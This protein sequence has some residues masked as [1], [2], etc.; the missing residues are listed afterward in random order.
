MKSTRLFLWRIVVVAMFAV[1]AKGFTIR[2]LNLRLTRTI[3]FPKVIRQLSA[4]NAEGNDVEPLPPMANLYREWSLDQDRL[5]WNNKERSS[6]ELAS[7]LGRGLRGVEARL[8]KLQDVSSPAYE[9]LFAGKDNVMPGETKERL[10]PV[11][12]VLRRIEWD[13]MLQASDFS[14]LHYDRVEDKVVESPMD[15]PNTSVAGKETMLAKALPEHRIV[16]VKYKERIVWDRNA[17]LDLV[18]SSPGIY[19]VMETY[20]EWKRE[21]DIVQTWNRERQ[22]AVAERI[23]TILGLQ[24]YGQLQQLS[25]ELLQAIDDPT[26][27]TK[28]EVEKYVQQALE[29]FRLVRKDPSLSSDPLL[30]PTGDFYALDELSELVAVLPN[31]ELREMLLN[32]I[33]TFMRKAEGK[34]KND[35]PMKVEIE[36]NEEE[37]TETFVRGSGPGGQKV[38]KTS[39]RVLLVHEPTQLR[40]ECQDTRSLQQNRK[41]ARKRLKEKLDEYLN[42][43][44]SKLSMKQQIASAKRQKSKSKNRARLRKK[45]LEKD[46]QQQDDGDSL[47]DPDD[48]YY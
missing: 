41:I 15:A 34:G 37:L 25:S 36:L 16:G 28:A 18:F 12:E 39:N 22:K 17:K 9:R 40:V 5:L 3:T 33:S 4:G 26:Q 45:Q 13:Y 2:S 11:G 23:K 32:E 20:D 29:L 44:Q 31:V 21:R 7:L 14:I 1:L 30:V 6:P 47:V 43:S 42:G 8:S 27:S 38:N 10:V 24:L 48:F 19:E 35:A 46:S